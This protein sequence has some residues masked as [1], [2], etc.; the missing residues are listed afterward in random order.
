L[1]VDA[2]EPTP[3]G[4]MVCLR[5]G[6]QRLGR[7]AANVDA[8]AADGAALDQQHAQLS[9]PRRDRGRERTATRPDDRQVVP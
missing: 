6:Q 2:G 5:G 1:R 8:G 9:A 3:I 4:P 7:D